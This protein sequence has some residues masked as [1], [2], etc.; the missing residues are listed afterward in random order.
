MPSGKKI[1]SPSFCSQQFRNFVLLLLRHLPDNIPVRV[2][3]LYMFLS[4][5]ISSLFVFVC[6]VLSKNKT[7]RLNKFLVPN[8]TTTT[9]LFMNIT[10]ML[11]Y[12]RMK[13]KLRLKKQ[14]FK[15]KLL[16]QNRT[17]SPI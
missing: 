10:N 11:F 8:Y 4:L 14:Q 2:Q 16:Q 3:G 9:Q 5:H 15:L 12:S 6:L 13:N 1:Y 17:R 7:T